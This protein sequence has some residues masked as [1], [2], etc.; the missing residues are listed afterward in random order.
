MFLGKRL[1]LLFN[2]LQ[3]GLCVVSFNIFWG[4]QFE[5]LEFFGCFFGVFD[6]DVFLLQE[7]LNEFI[8]E[9]E[10]F[11]WFC[12]YVD[13]GIEWQVMV[14][15]IVGLWSGILFV[16][17]YLM[18][19]CVFCWIFVE[20][21]GWDFLVC[22]VVVVIDVLIGMVFVV[23]VYLKV[24]GVVNMCEDECCFVEVDV[25]YCIFVGMKSVV[26]LKYVVFGGDF[27]FFG[28]LD[29]ICSMMCMFD[30]DGSLFGV[31]MLFVLGDEESV[32]IFGCDGLCSCFD[33]VIYFDFL[34]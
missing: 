7:W 8:L 5:M 34:L 6:V 33:Y 27:N 28:F 18:C 1:V 3:G 31:V 25:L 4:L 10:V 29:V 9:E 12:E 14:L 2:V 24:L 22:F 19:G 21:G 23:S 13:V 15:G 11:C 20:G 17:F 16:S 26:E 32:Y 30:F